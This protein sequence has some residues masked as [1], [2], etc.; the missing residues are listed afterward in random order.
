MISLMHIKKGILINPKAETITECFIDTLKGLEDYYTQ[1]EC[2]TFD[3]A[4]IGNGH[5]VYIDDE[6]LLNIQHDTKFF[7]IEGYY[8]PLVGN[9]IV[10]GFNAEDGETINCTLTIDEVKARV[11]FHTLNEVRQ[12][13]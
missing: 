4:H 9:G 11:K 12:M 3:I 8:Q 7:S 5:D 13:F 10:M 1:L 6:G 2:Q